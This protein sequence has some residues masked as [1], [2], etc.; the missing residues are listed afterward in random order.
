MALVCLAGWVAIARMLRP[1]K[2]LWLGLVKLVYRPVDA[3]TLTAGLRYE[4]VSTNS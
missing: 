4:T 1:I 2:L 3:L